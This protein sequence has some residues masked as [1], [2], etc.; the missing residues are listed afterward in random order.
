MACDITSVILKTGA[1]ALD[2]CSSTTV[3]TYSIDVLSLDG[4]IYEGT[5]CLGLPVVQGFFV[6]TG[7]SQNIWLG[8]DVAGGKIITSGVCAGT[9]VQFRSCEDGS[10]VFRFR[11]GT[12]PSTSGETYL[13]G[14]TVE[15][16]GCATIVENDGSGQLYDSDGVTFTLLTGCGDINCPRTDSKAAVLSKCSDGTIHY[17][18]VDADTAFPGTTYLYN[19]ECYK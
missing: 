8:T 2:A 4:V 18:N 7:T 12:L 17:F 6:L 9:T 3:G 15:F 1:T 10:V 19:S 16:E 5:G 14:G 11:G 13:I